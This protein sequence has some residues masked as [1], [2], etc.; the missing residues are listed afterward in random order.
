MARTNKKSELFFF[1]KT[2][3]YIYKS[4]DFQ[5]EYQDK[6]MVKEVFSTNGAGT[7]GYPNAKAFR[8]E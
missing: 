6:S 5:Q 7:T 3:I 8:L 1:K 2:G 4:T